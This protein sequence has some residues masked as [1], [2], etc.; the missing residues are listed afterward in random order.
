M[1]GGNTGV[2]A[3]GKAVPSLVRW[4]ASADA[5]LVYRCLVTFGSQRAGE[6]AADLGLPARRVRT[7]LE[8]LADAGLVQASREPAYGAEAMTWCAA[9]ADRAVT[10]L[11]RRALRRAV[12]ASADASAHRPIPPF[13]ARHLPDRDATRRRVAELMAVERVEHLAMHP[14]QAFSAEIVAVASPLD[15]AILQR[16]VRLRNLGRPPADGDRSAG[17]AAE[18]ARLG[19]RYREAARLP[20]KMMIFD[21]RVALLAVDPRDLS[22]GTWEVIDPVAVESL[23]TLFVRHWGDATDPRTN[24]VPAVVLTSREKALVGLLAEGYTD[25]HAAQHLGMSTRSVTYAL[26]ALMDR[27]GVENRFQL[28]LA[29]GA[30]RAAVPP[31]LSVVDTNDGAEA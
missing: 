4:G 5:D 27:L 11:R 2:L 10:V 26:R 3:L 7:A 13:A 1:A 16:G 9:P 8:E 30:L 18:I 22:R 12:V 25:A 6:V 19:G 23:V 31:G 28:G 15:I 17:H 29:L 14:E 21:R 24:G 20:H